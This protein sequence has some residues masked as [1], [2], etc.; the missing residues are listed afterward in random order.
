MA[1]GTVCLNKLDRRQRPGRKFSKT[2]SVAT[3]QHVFLLVFFAQAGEGAEVTKDC[4]ESKAAAL[5]Y[6]YSII[7]SLSS[8]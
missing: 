8:R 7:L 6:S 3:E 5:F 2:N 1:K 4:E